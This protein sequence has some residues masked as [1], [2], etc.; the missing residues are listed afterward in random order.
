[1]LP[2]ISPM[3]LSITKPF[4]SADHIFELKHDGFR[5][6]AYIE[7][8]ECKLVS[9]N[10]N[11][12]KSFEGLRKSLD[13][14]AENAILDGEVVCLD[15][16]GIS[17]FDHLMSRRGHP[18]FYAFDLLWLNGEDL[19]MFPLI[20]RKERLRK[21]VKKSA[22]DRLLYAQHIE[23]S[24]AAFFEEICQRNLEGIVAKP[25]NGAYKSNGRGWLKIKNPNYSQAEGRHELFKRRS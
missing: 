13:D 17:Q 2:R 7:N 15:T 11:N 24:G 12:F 1:M 3:R 6:I 25:K 10:L 9:R 4:D 20:D 19:R 21:L 5:A 23:G 8:G 18:V 22:C 16:H 14:L